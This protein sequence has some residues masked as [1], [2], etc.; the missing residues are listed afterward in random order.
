M[1]FTDFR[2]L[3]LLLR[4]SLAN[5]FEATTGF[6]WKAQTKTLNILKSLKIYLLLHFLN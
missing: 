2:S 5:K 4:Y 6:L 1:I 3:K